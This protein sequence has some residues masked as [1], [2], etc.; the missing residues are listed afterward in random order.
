MT[1]G[2]LDHMNHFGGAIIMHYFR[3]G[4]MTLGFL[5]HMNHFGDAIIMH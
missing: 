2:F 4:Y 3:R 1:L 5:D